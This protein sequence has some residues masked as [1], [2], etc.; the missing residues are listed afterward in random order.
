MDTNPT[1]Q[2]LDLAIRA[3]AAQDL[4]V[5]EELLAAGHRAWCAGVTEVR[6]SIERKTESSDAQVAQ[7]CAAADVPWEA[8]MTRGEAIAGLVFIYSMKCLCVR[9]LRAAASS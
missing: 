8:G 3:Q 6:T 2:L 1:A 4:A 7:R 9:L 5:L